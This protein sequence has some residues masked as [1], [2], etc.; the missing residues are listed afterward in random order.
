[1]LKQIDT[2][3]D[4]LRGTALRFHGVTVG[5]TVSWFD[6]I[7]NTFYRR[8]KV[9]A[10]SQYGLTLDTYPDNVPEMTVPWTCLANTPL[11]V[12]IM[13]TNPAKDVVVFTRRTVSG[14][15]NYTHIATK[16][17]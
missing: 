2:I 15:A 14:E 17:K 16:D 6:P 13:M 11:G 7:T 10:V 1:M 3:H 12:G 9:I 8:A 5:T 4:V